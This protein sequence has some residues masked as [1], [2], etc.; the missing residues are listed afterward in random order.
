M[1]TE[2]LQKRKI[3]N[4]VEEDGAI[5]SRLRKRKTQPIYDYDLIDD[6]VYIQALKDTE[7]MMFEEYR[8]EEERHRQLKEKK[9]QRGEDDDNSSDERETYYDLK[10]CIICDEET[11]GDKEK[12]DNCGHVFKISKGYVQDGFIIDDDKEKEND[13]DQS[14]A[15]CHLDNECDNVDEDDEEFSDNES[16][17]SDDGFSGD[18]DEE[19]ENLF[20]E[21]ESDE[22]END[23]DDSVQT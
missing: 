7:K 20:F 23:E 16:D 4:V 15:S 2:V 17:E 8:L 9:Q 1:S 12:C 11:E 3:D 5:C 18:S 13:N 19:E 14:S 22:E 6:D 21:G 10:M